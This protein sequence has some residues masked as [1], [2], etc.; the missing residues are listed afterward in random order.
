MKDPRELIKL[1]KAGNE[2]AFEHLYRQFAV[3]L[4]RYIYFRV[5][6][7]EDAED[8][9][10]SVFLKAYKALA[11]YRDTGNEPLAF[12]Y[13]I[14]RNAI[15]DN[16]RKKREMPLEDIGVIADR[17][18]EHDTDIVRHISAKSH[19]GDIRIALAGLGEDQREAIT[20]RFIHDLE[21]RE[22]AAVLG[23][24]EVAVRQLQSR[25]L[26]ALREIIKP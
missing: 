1:A 6:R 19:L 21:N 25:G 15:I 20:M 2:E 12:F 17:V 4:F 9:L 10:Q 18:G 24:T 22:I 26:R 11:E 16:Q 8:I 7:K 13:T 5:N 14:A 23:K 3:P